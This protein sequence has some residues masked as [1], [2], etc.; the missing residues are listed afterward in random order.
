MI[1]TVVPKGESKGEGVADLFFVI[2]KYSTGNFKRIEKKELNLNDLSAICL[3]DFFSPK[4][5]C[6]LITFSKNPYD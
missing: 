2:K 6:E 5:K 3:E 1:K 4:M